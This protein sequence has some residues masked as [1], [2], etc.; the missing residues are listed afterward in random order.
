MDTARVFDYA[1]GGFGESF[2]MN[3][4]LIWTACLAA[5]VS[6]VFAAPPDTIKIDGGQIS[7]VTTDGVSSFKGIPFAAALGDLRMEAAAAGCGLGW[8]QARRRLRAPV[9][10]AAAPS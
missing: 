2:A 5:A 4:R 3:I 7:G 9:P 1:S 8:H 6:S 10:P